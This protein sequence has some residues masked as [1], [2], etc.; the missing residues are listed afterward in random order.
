[1]YS[2]N[3]LVLLSIPSG[4]GTMPSADKQ[5]IGLPEKSH[6]PGTIHTKQFTPH[7]DATFLAQACLDHRE[8]QAGS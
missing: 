7:S 3:P 6:S 4:P 1:M 2:F 8:S 5:L